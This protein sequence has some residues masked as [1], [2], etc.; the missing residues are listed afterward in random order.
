MTKTQVT[1]RKAQARAAAGRRG[2]RAAA[3]AGRRRQQAVAIAGRRGRLAAQA[4]P[5]AASAAEIGRRG[6][7]RARVWAAPRLDRTG[8]ALEDRVAPRVAAMLSATAR[9]IEPARPKRRRWPLVAAGLVA[10]AGLSAT[11]AFLMSRRDSEAVPM[12]EP[13][14]PAF[15]TAATSPG[16]VH[17]QAHEAADGR[18]HTP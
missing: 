14:E 15:G 16:N 7:H 1:S 18:V 10:A 5:L 8:Q 11:A 17:N 12:S 2:R 9:R 4:A 3:I 6:V 13:A